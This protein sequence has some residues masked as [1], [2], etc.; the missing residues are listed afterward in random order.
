[1]PEREEQR[2]SMMPQLV[3]RPT[4]ASQLKEKATTPFKKQKPATEPIRRS[5]HIAEQTTKQT[6]KS[7]SSQKGMPG[8]LFQGTHP[9]YEGALYAEI[10]DELKED[11]IEGLQISKRNLLVH[12]QKSTFLI[13]SY[14]ILL[15][16]TTSY[17]SYFGGKKGISRNKTSFFLLM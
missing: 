14:S 3:S 13:P 17:S 8:G 16:L 11:K 12:Q 10:K 1:M 6:G 9:N 4:I 7:S 5:Q 2:K 15:H